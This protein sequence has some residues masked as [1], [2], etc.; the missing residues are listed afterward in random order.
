MSLHGL[1]PRYLA[2]LCKPVTTSLFSRPQ[3]HKCR[4]VCIA[5]TVIR[6]TLYIQSQLCF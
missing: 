3:N 6:I 5:L 1:A 2:D 4:S